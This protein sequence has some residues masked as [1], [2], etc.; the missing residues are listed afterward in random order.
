MIDEQD[1]GRHLQQVEVGPMPLQRG[2]AFNAMGQRRHRQVATT[3]DASAAA[4]V[5]DAALEWAIG[6]YG[7]PGAH[8]A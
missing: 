4:A 7:W 6:Q 8:P 2:F 5:M 3:W 1:K